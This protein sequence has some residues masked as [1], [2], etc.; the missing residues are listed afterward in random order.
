MLPL[1][2]ENIYWNIWCCFWR[3]SFLVSVCPEFKRKASC[4]LRFAKDHVVRNGKIVYVHRTLEENCNQSI[5]CIR[6]Y[7]L[8]HMY[9]SRHDLK[10][11]M[12][13]LNEIWICWKVSSHC[14]QCIAMLQYQ[15]LVLLHWGYHRISKSVLQGSSLTY[16][17]QFLLRFMN[18]KLLHLIINFELFASTFLGLGWA[19]TIFLYLFEYN[20]YLRIICW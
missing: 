16:F 17:T 15:V 8:E 3:K 9:H 11:A 13:F 19:N 7:L 6:Y 5:I 12:T 1:A 18:T 20:F 4:H 2:L 14:I 10:I